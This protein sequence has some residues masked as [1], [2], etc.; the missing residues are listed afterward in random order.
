MFSL[1]LHSDAYPQRRD[2]QDLPWLD[3]LGEGLRVRLGARLR[4]RAGRRA[5]VAVRVEAEEE[6]LAQLSPAERQAELAELKRALRRDGFDKDALVAQAFAQVRLESRHLL[7]KAHFGTQIEGAYVLLHGNIAE[8]NTGEG[9]SLTATL[10]AAT[11]A[12]AGMKVHIVTVNDYLAGRDRDE[13][14]PL[15]AAL[16]LSTGLVA[17]TSTPQ[18]KAASYHADIVYCS[19]KTIVFDYLRD[20]LALGERM[21]PLRLAIDAMTGNAPRHLL[22]GLQ[23]AIVDEAD[24]VFVD[25]ART[26][27]IIS[28]A[29][30]SV[31]AETFYREAVDVAGELLP[32]EDYS[33]DHQ[34]RQVSLTE[35]GRLRLPA[36]VAARTRSPVWRSPLRAEEAAVLALQALHVFQRDIHYI[37]RDDKVMIVD[38]NTGRVMPDRSWERGLQQLIEVKEGAALSAE[39][40]TLGRISYQLFFRR[41]LRL[42][43]MSGTCREVSG[44][45]ADVYGLGVVGIA[46]YRPSR[47]QRLPARLFASASSR[48]QAVMESVA[49][50]SGAGRPVLVGTRSIAA[51]EHIAALLAAAGI[52][53]QLLNAKQDQEEAATVALAG[54]AGRVTIATNMAG[55]GTDIKLDDA[56]RE[57]GGLH[58]ILTELHDASRVDRQLAGRCARM[59]DPG[60]WE[61]ILSLEDELV[62]N[63][64][65][66]LRAWVLPRL[67]AGGPRGIWHRLALGLYRLAQWRTEMGHARNRGLLLRADFRSRQALSFTGEME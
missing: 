61:E 29:R 16:G 32:D 40:E 19:N 52:P 43:G 11:A 42:S 5:A 39:K 9:K 13:F 57:C 44:E 17:E 50:H 20:R 55:R 49:A 48:W 56:V 51:S 27:L 26:P 8:M 66:P 65:P 1:T 6:R 47:R 10:A 45:L 59:G 31:E 36:V 60:S 18:E 58:V 21:Q 15:Y 63:F 25:E 30:H 3:R 2:W 24:S 53:H 14:A 37:V 12:L 23:F 28:A 38:E 54:D 33:F 62:A 22:R 7:G 4:L 34:Q 46:P 64:L 41:Y 35:C 67:A